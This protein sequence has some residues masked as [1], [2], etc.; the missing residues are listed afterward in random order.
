MGVWMSTSERR[1]RS[2]ATSSSAAS[3]QPKSSGMR[4]FLLG[5]S[6]ALTR[7]LK[8]KSRASV[9]YAVSD[10]VHLHVDTASFDGLFCRGLASSDEY[11]HYMPPNMPLFPV[12]EP[13]YHATCARTWKSLCMGSTPKMQS[14]H[15][16]GIVLFYDEFFHRLFQRDPSFTDVFPGIRKRIEV[17]IKALKFMLPETN[18]TSPID[19]MHRCRH[20]GH[21][22]RTI[23]KVRPHHFAVYTSTLIEVAMFWLDNEA[24]PDV[25]EAWSNLVGFHLK[26]MLQAYLHENVV[27]SEWSQNVTIPTAH[28]IARKK[29]STVLT[30][31]RVSG[32][33]AQRPTIPEPFLATA[34]P[35]TAPVVSTPGTPTTAQLRERRASRTHAW[36]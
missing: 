31:A 28:T 27:P 5:F 9:I 30:D 22:H 7:S 6:T 23:K 10:E 34:A 33:P 2:A 3:T 14:Y 11:H 15:K 29:S 16:D 1:R 26:F 20:L 25:G 18:A 8:S 21:R 12:Y 35:E 36:L 24:T 17:L 19:V 4:S 32:R 13:S